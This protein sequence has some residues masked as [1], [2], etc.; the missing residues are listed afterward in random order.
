[1]R[2][3]KY[4]SRKA[5]HVKPLV[6]LLTL[7]LVVGCAVGGTLAWLTAQTEEVE[8]TFT[9]GNIDIDLTET[10]TDYKMIPGNDI[11]KDPKVTVEAG[12][13]D[14]WVYVKVVKSSNFDSY[15]TYEIADGW[16]LLE[17]NGNTAVYYRE[18]KGTA[19]A[20]Y[21]VLKDNEVHVKDSV[22]KQMMDQIEKNEVAN[23]TLTFTAYAI[24]QANIA[25]AEAGWTQ[26]NTPA[27]G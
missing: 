14:S 21:D 2:N 18:Y 11:A 20:N 9:V 12:S 17:K 7:A 1:M 13:E 26:L 10:T 16:T 8:N 3:G 27:Q 22:T 19:V 24:Q 25:S 6:L 5:S 23:P 15:L 4:S